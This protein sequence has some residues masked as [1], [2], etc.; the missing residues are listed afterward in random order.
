MTTELY[1]TRDEAGTDRQFGVLEGPDFICQTLEDTVR[2]IEGVPIAAWKIDGQTAIPRGRYKVTWT[3]SNR[4]QKWMPLLVGVEGFSGVRIHAGN[5]GK[6]TLG[7][8]LI[9]NS[10]GID[11]ITN[12]RVACGAF[13]TA[14]QG[15]LALGDCWITIQ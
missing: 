15:W 11:S 5:T 14:L 8:I 7:C 3:Y 9:G 1:L 13:Y 6:D 2:E 12:S 10:R 4:F